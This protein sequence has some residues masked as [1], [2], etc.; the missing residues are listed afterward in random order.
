MY[1]GTSWLPFI[2][3]RS[4]PQLAEGR[5]PSLHLRRE[6]PSPSL[7]HSLFRLPPI[8][9]LSWSPPRPRPATAHNSVRRNHPPPT[10]CCWFHFFYS[11][12]HHRYG[13]LR[14]LN[15]TTLVQ[16]AVAA[17][18][19]HGEGAEAVEAPNRVSRAHPA[20]TLFQSTWMTRH[21]VRPPQSPRRQF[22]FFPTHPP[23]PL[24]LPKD[25]PAVI[26]EVILPRI[27]TIF[28][29]GKPEAV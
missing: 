3:R 26:S 21:L 17:A 23:P 5:C 25:H 18:S 11:R 29:V 7:P 15:T 8:I 12:R 16:R 6:R 10:P 24:R 27:P 13:P 14:R 2:D 9:A 22:C 1:C 28:P 19:G 4:W 20:S